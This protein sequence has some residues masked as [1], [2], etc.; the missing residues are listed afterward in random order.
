M[1]AFQTKITRMALLA[2]CSAALTAPLAVFAQDTPPLPPAQ[3]SGGPG[4]G[5]PGGGRGNMAARMQE[6]EAR[7]LDM[8]TTQLSLTPDQ[9]AAIKQ[10]NADSDAKMQAAFSNQSGGDMRSQMMALRQDRETKTRA[11]LTPAQ[12]PKYD[13]MMAQMRQ[14]MGSPGGNGGGGGTPPPPPPAQQ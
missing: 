3:N 4:A 1:T 14:R 2:V 7:Q 12:Q 8:M 5:G 11:V 6:R 9:V 10:I 13:D